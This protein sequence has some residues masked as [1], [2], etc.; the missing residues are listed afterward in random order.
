MRLNYLTPDLFNQQLQLLN[1]NMSRNHLKEIPVHVMQ[2]VPNLLGLDL[3]NNQ[4]N[5]LPETILRRL[6]R[7]QHLRLD[8]NPWVCDQCH[9]PHFKSWINNS[10]NFQNACYPNVDAVN[11]LKCQEPFELFDK[12]IIELE[13]FSLQPCA[14]GSSDILGA[15]F[16]STN[17]TLVLAIVTASVIIILLLV[18]LAVGLIM[19]NRHSTV[20]YDGE[21]TSR[22]RFYGNPGLYSNHTD[23]TNAGDLG[24]EVGGR[25]V[26]E[27]SR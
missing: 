18:I 5:G 11:C 17:I 25:D 9:V 3:S 4:I 12:P 16:G 20:Y 27:M 21:S 15:A 14:G 2:S 23:V 1:L 10:K 26:D 7:I 8:G 6:G 24:C 19:Y 22:R 13:G